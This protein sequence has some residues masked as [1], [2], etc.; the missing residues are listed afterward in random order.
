MRR[1]CR[2]V[3]TFLAGATVLLSLAVTLPVAANAAQSGPPSGALI[4]NN[5]SSTDP[6]ALPGACA[7]AAFTTI[8][9]AETAATA[10][11]TIYVCAGSY[12][13][14]VSIDKNL[15]FDGAQFGVD[16]R[17]GRVDPADETIVDAPAAVSG[18][19]NGFTYTSTATSGTIDGFTIS[20]ANEPTLTN[21]YA[22]VAFDDT[23][24]GYH[25]VNNVITHEYYA[26]FVDTATHPAQTVIQHNLVEYSAEVIWE[27]RNYG[28]G[29]DYSA[30]NVLIDSNA[31]QFNGNQDVHYDGSYDLSNKATGLIVTNNTSLNDAAFVLLIDTSG[32]RISNNTITWTG[33]P[34][35][36]SIT[37]VGAITVSSDNANTLISDNTITG[38]QLDPAVNPLYWDQ[39]AITTQTTYGS[40]TPS[41]GVTIT[42]NTL[43]G[44]VFGIALRNTHS[45]LAAAGYVI[46]DNTISHPVLATGDTCTIDAN[47]YLGGGVGIFVQ[48]QNYFPGSTPSTT[49]QNRDFSITGNTVTDP[50]CKGIW[51]QN[52][53]ATSVDIAATI[54][55]NTLTGA[56]VFDCQDQTTGS[57]TA[58]TA[59]TWTANIGHLSSPAGLCVATTSQPT[60]A[61]ASPAGDGEDGATAAGQLPDT[62][63]P[64]PPLLITS[65]LLLATGLALLHTARRRTSA[66]RHH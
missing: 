28:P 2:F 11:K 35:T 62:G 4:V 8:Q 41:V 13:E 20:A 16:A 6:S 27:G 32:A 50:E 33:G 52:V 66:A 48:D 64:I 15:I 45:A 63:T 39:F 18:N 55:G 38:A 43:S 22:I 31:F 14:A 57:A 65:A 56:A 26:A 10:G 21:T 5:S 23:G 25:W 61:G 17:T 24:G 29:A 37:R 60:S 51:V 47:G 12:P 44:Q 30:N 40:T 59:N 53:G 34:A 54:T 58:G 3:A 46:S 1:N 19:T 49:V 42:H 9:A 36:N 7:S